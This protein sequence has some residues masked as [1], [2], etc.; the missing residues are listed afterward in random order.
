MAEHQGG[1]SQG[2]LVLVFEFAP[3][4]DTLAQNTGLL[5]R[6]DTPRLRVLIKICISTDLR[7]DQK[8]LVSEAECAKPK[9]SSLLQLKLKL[10][11]FP[12]L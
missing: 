5:G 8:T 12:P 6:E 9:H 10:K 11:H 3:A 1:P 2:H 4:G 7:Q